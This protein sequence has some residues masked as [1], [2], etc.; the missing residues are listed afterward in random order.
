MAA[1]PA[2][3]ALPLPAS[4]GWYQPANKLT[5]RQKGPSLVLRENITDWPSL[6]SHESLASGRRD[7]SSSGGS[8]ESGDK[9]GPDL[10]DDG[11]VEEFPLQWHNDHWDELLDY[12]SPYID[13]WPGEDWLTTHIERGDRSVSNEQLYNDSTSQQW[14]QRLAGLSRSDFPTLKFSPGRAFRSKVPLFKDQDTGDEY[15]IAMYLYNRLVYTDCPRDSIP[16]NERARPLAKVVYQETPSEITQQDAELPR[17]VI[18]LGPLAIRTEHRIPDPPSEFGPPTELTDYQVVLDAEDEA[19][20]LWILC[21]RRTLRERHQVYGGRNRQLPIF[22]GLME[23]EEYGYDAACML[24][25][26]H[27]LR[28][29]LSYEESC[30]M[31]RR[32]RAVV[33]PVSRYATVEKMEELIG[34]P[35]PDN[36]N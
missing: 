20:P 1:Q 14:L 5:L 19:M 21:S 18:P 8:L 4:P 28:D 30:D 16:F 6:G 3:P 10:S 26:V 11:S 35:V 12:E 33:D 7:S 17:F 34:G 25:S 31:V 13:T 2:Q 9:D 24:D 23:Y 32:T 27:R 36:L 29:R 15:Q 22:K